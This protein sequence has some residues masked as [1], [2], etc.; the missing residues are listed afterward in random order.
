M[1][2]ESL[3]HRFASQNI[4]SD[5][6]LAFGKNEAVALLGASGSGKTTLLRILA[7]ILRPTSGQVFLNQIPHETSITDKTK[8][9]WPYITC[10]FQD[11]FLFPNLT[12][13]ENCVLG[14]DSSEALISDLKQM[15]DTLEIADCIDRKP[16]HISHGQAQR[17]AIIRALIR[18][19][20]YLLLDEPTSALDPASREQLGSLLDTRINEMNSSLI[21]A[22]H[23]WEFASSIC[24]RF[25]A[26]SGGLANDVSDIGK[27][28]ELL[29]HPQNGATYIK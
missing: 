23:D 25:I 1:T 9:L 11:L 12:V 3:S 8:R 16:R 13:R 21:I 22:T 10:V 28:A 6:D 27:A 26:L 14:L 2:T 5:V 7:G 4:F 20:K 15:L 18:K 24:K 19:P 29:T 17:A